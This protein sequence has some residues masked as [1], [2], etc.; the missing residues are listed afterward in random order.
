VNNSTD[1]SQSIANFQ[2]VGFLTL[3]PDA[4][5]RFNVDAA[6]VLEAAG[7]GPHALEDPEAGIPYAV[8]GRILSVAVE[9]T[10]C[11]EF[12]LEIGR[13]IR[14]THLGLLG[15]LMRN[16]PN[17][18]IALMDFAAHQH[19]N[20]HGGIAYLLLDKESS[21]LGY[22]VY[23]QNVPGNQLICDGAAMAAFNLVTELAGR[24]VSP[25]QTVLFSRAE[26]SDPRPWH[27]SFRVKLQFNADKTG[28]L[29]PTRCLDL[30]IA[31]ANE[32][33]RPTLERRIAT[34]WNA[35]ALDTATRL[36]RELRIALMTGHLSGNDMSAQLGVSRRTLHRRLAAQ[37]LRFQQVVDE[38][39]YEFARQLL[40]NTE[41]GI[42]E[43]GSIVGYT[44]PSTFTRGFIRAAGLPPSEWRFARGWR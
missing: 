1:A 22:A 28:V 44:D 12:A 19:R 3:I 15:E 29:F 7:L 30:P 16:A 23:Q 4:L 34:L 18:R 11:P 2:R 21:F 13:Q 42:A 25:V 5:R 14:T 33:L 39:R 24:S 36:R 6:E 9:K 26:P 40:E 37:G 32:V 27:R 31:G 17:L 8:M 38:I 10:R 41:L 35:G 43:I 20:A